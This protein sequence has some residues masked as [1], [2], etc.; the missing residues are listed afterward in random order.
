M[1]RVI[2][3]QRKG[4]GSVF[5]AHVKHRKGPAKL[6]AVDFA[7]RHGYIKGI[8]KVGAGSGGRGPPAGSSRRAEAPPKPPGLGARSPPAVPKGLR[9]FVPQSGPPCALKGEAAAGLRGPFCKGAGSSTVFC[10]SFADARVTSA[11]SCIA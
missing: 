5:R 9:P 1:G 7:E 4:A 2:R 11:C 8:V 10:R 3:G 6:R